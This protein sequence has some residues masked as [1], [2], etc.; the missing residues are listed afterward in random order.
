MKQQKQQKNQRKPIFLST[1]EKQK[2]SNA[3]KI[4]KNKY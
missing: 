1:G 2:Y 4:L 3:C